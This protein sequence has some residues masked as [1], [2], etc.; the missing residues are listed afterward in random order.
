MQKISTMG[1]LLPI[2]LKFNGVFIVFFFRFNP[3]VSKASI[4]IKLSMGGSFFV[5]LKES[6]FIRLFPVVWKI[7]SVTR[8]LPVHKSFHL[9]ALN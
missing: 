1:L 3:T 6:A 4:S 2:A 9:F 7:F 5:V 8:S